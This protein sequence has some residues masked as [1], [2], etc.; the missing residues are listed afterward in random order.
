MGRGQRQM[1]FA[2]LASVVLTV[3]ACGV[4]HASWSP[5]STGSGLTTATSI[6][7][8]NSPVATATSWSTTSVSWAAPTGPSPTQYVVRRT[9]PTTATVCTV[10]GS[11]FGCTDSGL[12]ASTTYTY[13]VEA[14]L[15]AWSSGATGGFTATTPTPTFKVAPAS[16][17]RTA[18]GAFAVVLTATTNGTTTD[19]SYTGSHAV[20]FS[21]P[22]TSPSGNAPVYP[23]S[24]TFAA[25]V[26]TASVTL[27]DT[28]TTTMTVTDGTRTG[29]APLTVAAGA[30][31]RLVFSSSTPDCASGSVEV[32]VLGTFTSKVTVLDHYANPVPQGA[33]IS[34][35]LTRSPGLGSFSPTSVSIAAGASQSTSA[36]TYRAPLFFFFDVTVTASRAGLTAATCTV[37]PS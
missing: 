34:V 28:E 19:T 4:A 33:A 36:F 27:V 16:G 17:T 29:S 9:A 31:E 5:P 1:L 7:L 25:G 23:A 13:T 20:S 22:G 6:G 26:G 14:R 30:S 37:Q 8:P 15:G 12:S 11:T 3:T 32:G 10:G 24:V 21:G 35:A 18:G 2:L